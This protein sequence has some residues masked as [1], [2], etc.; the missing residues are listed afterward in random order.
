[1]SDYR[2]LW[3]EEKENARAFVS[4]IQKIGDEDVWL[5]PLALLECMYYQLSE[6]KRME[7]FKDYILTIT[8][9]PFHMPGCADRH[10]KFMEYVMEHYDFSVSFNKK[11]KPGD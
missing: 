7:I 10:Q 3:Q 1:M 11:E 5:N 6:V 2:K 8:N 9:R 4:G